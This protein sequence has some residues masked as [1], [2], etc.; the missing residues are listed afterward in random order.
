MDFIHVDCFALPHN[1]YHDHTIS[2]IAQVHS[3]SIACLGAVTTFNESKSACKSWV[4]GT[5]LL[6]QWGNEDID[7]AS[8][9]RA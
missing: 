1:R 9:M 8:G 5:G 4:S 6:G 7:R 3:C 2:S